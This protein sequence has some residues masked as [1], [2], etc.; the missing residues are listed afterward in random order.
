MNRREV[1]DLIDEERDYQKAKWNEQVSTSKG[2]HTWEEW[3]LYME[4]Y[5]NEAKRAL[6]RTPQPECN[7]KAACAVRKV[8]ALGVAGMEKL[9]APS[10]SEEGARPMGFCE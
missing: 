4:D 3:I 1:Y 7:F 2:N 6:S 5:L 10:R 9:G 8:V